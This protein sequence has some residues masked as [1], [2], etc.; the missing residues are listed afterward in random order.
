MIS[1]ANDGKP[2][3]GVA[4]RG[5]VGDTVTLKIDG[6]EVKA[7]AG[8]SI[9]EAAQAYGIY[10]PHL[11]HHPILK[12]QGGCKMCS[13]EIEGRAG[14][15]TAC[16]T[17]VEEG[18]EVR[19]KTERTT[20][21]RNVS[22][23]LML[24][25][26]PADCTSCA[27]YLNCELQNLMQYLG[28]AHSRLRRITK[29]NTGLAVGGANPLIKREPDRCILCGRC[30]RACADLRGVG[31]LEYRSRDGEAYVGVKDGVTLLESDCR[32]CGACVEVCPTGAIQDMPGI[33]PTGVKRELAMV[34]CKSACPAHTD[35]PLY[36]RYTREGKYPEAVAILREKLTFPHSLGVVCTRKCEA[37]CKR[38]HL[39]E[40][41]SIRNVKRFAVEHDGEGAWRSRVTVRPASGKRVAVVGAG[42]CGLTAAWHLQRLGHEVTVYEQREKPGGMLTYGI[43]TYR[44]DR[45]IVDGEIG[46]LSEMG[47]VIKTGERVTS[48]AKLATEYDGVV[49]AVGA[50]AGSPSFLDVNDCANAIPGVAFARMATEDALPDMGAFVTVLGGGSVAFDCARGAKKA[51]AAQVRLICLEKR[52]N[53]LADDEEIEEALAEGIEIYSGMNCVACEKG[54]AKDGT[55]SFV[56]SVTAVVVNSFA[57]GPQGLSMDTEPG[58]ERVFPTDTLV[59]A[60]GQRIDLDETFGLE[61]GRA[62]SV[63]TDEK[64][65]A[66]VP[67]VFAAGDAVTGTKSVVEA[68]A[69]GM[70]AAKNVDLWLGGDGTGVFDEVYLERGANDAVLGDGCGKRPAARSEDICDCDAAKAET[71]RCLSC[72]LRLDIPKVRFWGDAA[73]KKRGVFQGTAGDAMQVAPGDAAFKKRGVFQGDGMGEMQDVPGRSGAMQADLGNTG[74]GHACGGDVPI[75]DIGFAPET[76]C[77]VDTARK[78]AA[79][80]AALSCG[81]CVL[82]R[83]GM[84]QAAAILSDDVSGKGE[85]ADVELL[86]EILALVR[87]GA[88]LLP[89][90]PGASGDVHGGGGDGL[91]GPS[92]GSGSCRMAQSAAGD[93]LEL[94]SSHRDE[95]YGHILRKRCTKQVCEAYR[96]VQGEDRPRRQRRGRD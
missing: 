4:G 89:P 7:A 79:Q 51:G 8:K 61:L 48:A 94:L 92:A 13:V 43:P 86:G 16:N 31:A 69:M 75:V 25:S 19:T 81:K 91:A 87:D 49:V 27:V 80:A 62:N 96:P 20:H 14:T 42:P 11:C 58:S 88:G 90:E 33:F 38:G 34:P 41:L 6:F 64:L 46:T 1:L 65:A 74:P 36:L 47:F 9:L 37:G 57:F 72:H 77:P 63:K 93:I 29:N 52:E 35:I 22:L 17:A 2:A 21:V 40:A 56:K 68:V 55:G 3:A 78:I 82:C 71:E 18:M 66:S 73:F 45:G 50:Q 54:A 59:Y 30:V 95:F 83:D 12:P 85:E 5:R 84:A 44:L 60:T 10:I 53:M 23:E 24:A 15:V 39:D 67:G 32:F 70:E 28:V 26:H 76:D